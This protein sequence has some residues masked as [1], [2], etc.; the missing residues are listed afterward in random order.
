MLQS[1]KRCLVGAAWLL[2]IGVALVGCF[3]PDVGIALLVSPE[4]LNFGTGQD[5]LVLT[6]NKNSSA[7]THEPIVATAG[8]DWIVIEACT[9]GAENCV[10]NFPLDNVRIPVRI[11][12]EKMAL[13]VNTSIITLQSGGSSQVQVPVLADDVLAPWFSVVNRQVG[14][15]QALAFSDAS[16]SADSVGPIRSWKWDFGDGNTS[17]TQ[18]PT[19]LYERPGVYTVSLTV[20]TGSRTETRTVP[21]FVT[22]GSPTPRVDFSAS[23]TTVAVNSVVTFT[24]LTVSPDAPLVS[25]RWDFGDGQGSSETNP[26][27]QYTKPGFYT[28]SLTVDNVFTKKTETKRDFIIVQNTVAP[29][30]RPTLATPTPFLN[31][32]LQF[33]DQ[34]IDGS[35]PITQWAWTF[36][37]G[38]ASTEENPTHTYRATGTYD[39][40]LTVSS[41]HGNDTATIQV[42]IPFKPPFVSFGADNQNPST[43]TPVNFVDLSIGGSGKIVSWAWTFGD[44]GVSTLQNPVHAYTKAGTY[45]VSLTLK[46]DAPANNTDTLVKEDFIIVVDAPVPGFTIST[47]SPF[48][49]TQ[50]VFSN[51]TVPGTE[52]PLTYLWDFDGN[53]DTVGDTSTEVNPT[54]TYA[55]AGIYN[56]TLTVSTDTR[57][58]SVSHTLVVD[59]VTTVGFR[60]QPVS[61]TTI[62]PV[63]FT[64]LSVAGARGNPAAPQTKID[65]RRWTFG[66]GTQ[67]TDTNPTHLYTESGRYD[68][69]LMITYTHSGSGATFRLTEAKAQYITVTP[70]SPPVAN[71][72]LNNEDCVFAGDTVGFVDTSAAGTLGIDSYS[73]DFGDGTTSLARN[74]NK[75]YTTAG[76]YTVALTVT[77]NT[78]P[79]NLGV[80]TISK[81][82]VVRNLTGLDAFVRDVDPEYMYTQ[83]S[84]FNVSAGPLSL[85]TAYNLRMTSQRWRT[86]ADI[87]TVDIDR[88]LWQH[89]LLVFVPT[90]RTNDT[91]LFLVTGGS[92]D[93]QPY[94]PAD[95]ADLSAAEIA[96]ATGSVLAV[97]DNVPAQPII[98]LDPADNNQPETN[99]DGSLRQRSE[100]EILAW[101]FDRFL[102]NPSL[103][104]Y[105]AATGRDPWPV[106]HAMAKAT[107]RGMDTVEDF[108]T[109]VVG[110]SVDDFVIT[111][112]SKRGWTTWLAGLTDCRV[113]AI[114]PIVFDVLN[115]A[116]Q[117]QHH[118]AVYTGQT[119]G[120]S[121]G[122][123]T[124]IQDYT[125]LG[126][127]DRLIP[128]LGGRIPE[129]V[130]AAG[131][132]LLRQID[133]YEY[134][135]RSVMPKF[136][137]NGSGDEF[138]VSD[139][140][141]F[142][143]D[144][145]PGETNLSYVP[146]AGH[147]LDIDEFGLDLFNNENVAAVLASWY[148]AIV[149]DVPRAKVS[150]AFPEDNTIVA[151]LD[152]P[153]G[154]TPEVRMWQVDNPDNRDFRNPIT[155]DTWTYQV[156]SPQPDGRYI[157]TVTTPALGWR[158]YYIQVIFDNGAQPALTFPGAPDLK[159]VFST[160]IRVVPDE[161]PQP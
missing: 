27:H 22:V 112:A 43:G 111:G 80:S 141:Q 30:A 78:L 146:N 89:N 113:R 20:S 123:S 63:A 136:L 93:N 45:D 70:P 38:A 52:L 131:L 87:Y 6:V 16:Q 139:S 66:D 98:F 44:G 109:R 72:D 26:K 122:Y 149:Q 55:T 152:N 41:A 64:D 140:A 94:T 148:L 127:F 65:G 40:T 47:D 106:V 96:A 79:P 82:V 153:E 91:V 31:E 129:D 62:T 88:T 33:R 11:L 138:F 58:V 103:G 147:G 51:T 28:V 158:A 46:T 32:P 99:P 76:V 5:R 84:Q 57:S 104:T 3:P 119:L 61:T 115:I 151:T 116:R 134:R 35:A 7:A 155:G 133:P 71:F 75:T 108:M 77:N 14:V 101:S 29:E 36:G 102:A 34:S 97:L 49:N 24:D 110:N 54:R 120:I 39:V 118:K 19:H 4:E 144:D 150:F 23:P 59:G 126:I 15:G 105:N 95:I 73:W 124:A 9:E 69:S 68:V 13:G 121:G 142:Y 21:S 90:N 2:G 37:D 156:L 81:E 117:M 132:A 86:A 17:A 107:V 157:G 130:P 114:A 135:Q 1:G 67:G 56:P 8:A 125:D 128:P 42:V 83:G 53:P 18:N 92:R 25:R 48:T 12:R 145:L 60:G 160:P 161:Y 74:P 100:D 10:S 85:G 137:I 154:T 50:V 159:F 143:V